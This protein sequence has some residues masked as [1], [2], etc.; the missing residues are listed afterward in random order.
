MVDLGK[1]YKA[2]SLGDGPQTTFDRPPLTEPL[3]FFGGHAYGDKTYTN[4]ADRDEI[5]APKFRETM[6]E[7]MGG[8]RTPNFNYLKWGDDGIK[9]LAVVLPLCGQL[10]TLEWSGHELDPEGARAAGAGVRAV[11]WDERRPGWAG[12][13]SAWTA[14]LVF[15]GSGATSGCTRHLGR[16]ARH[17]AKNAHSMGST[18]SDVQRQSQP[19][20]V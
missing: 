7:V 13:P 19:S 11:P 2:D 6:F 16:A 3:A 8:V 18:E 4:G 12:S 17:G 14:L 15:G 10:T 20:A 5:V 1:E 9:A